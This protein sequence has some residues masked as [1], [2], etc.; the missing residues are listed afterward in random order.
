MGYNRPQSK[1]LAR[2]AMRGAYPHPML[3]ALVF[4]LLTGVL[5]SMVLNFVNDPF[6]AA[7]YYL[8]ETDYTPYEILSAIF[9]PQRVLIIF[10]MELLL[11]LY[12]W[13]MAYGY[14]SYSLR[15][16]RREGPGY[17]N[18]LDGFYNIGRAMGVQFMTGLLT[19][20]W[21]LP[22]L[23]LTALCLVS[24]GLTDS[25]VM[26]SLASLA[27]VASAIWM[28]AVSYRYRL[29]TYFLLDDPDMGV[30]TALGHSRRA[31]GGYRLEL[32]VQD[33]SF[34]GWAILS[35]FTLGILNLWLLP[36]MSAA[37]ANFYQSVEYGN[38]TAQP[39]PGPWQGPGG[40]W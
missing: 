22:L 25:A 27:A 11:S 34:L 3:V 5:S 17:R 1:W 9:T 10:V 37:E 28:L 23:I 29:A 13:V 7:Y 36:Y 8:L 21:G 19:F 12:T 14:T 38:F 39:Q 16:A 30:M 6:Q 15:L 24:A 32:F 2:D 18:L 20:L 26:A 31:M 4:V 40:S 35:I 33:L